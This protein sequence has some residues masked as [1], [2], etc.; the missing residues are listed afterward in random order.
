MHPVKK[1]L[2]IVPGFFCF[3]FGLLGAIFF[4]ISQ[5]DMR[6]RIT[7]IAVGLGVAFFGLWLARRVE[8]SYAKVFEAL[9]DLVFLNWP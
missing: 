9:L 1:A 2:F 5:G 3:V 6:G 7:G 4:G 8:K